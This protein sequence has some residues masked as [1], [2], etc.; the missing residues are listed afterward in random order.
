[1]QRVVVIGN[2][3]GGKSTLSRRLSARLSLPCHEI[4]ALLWQP[5]WVETPADVYGAEHARLLAGE[6]W[7]IEGLGRRDSI[8]MRLARASDIVLIDLPLWRHFQFAA[9]RQ[10]AWATGR[11]AH[12][13]GGHA[14]L[15]PIEA[16]FRTIDEVDRIWMP[17]VRDRVA[18]CESAGTRVHRLVTV[19]DLDRF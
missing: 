14:E 5:G 7:I 3:G 10:V 6:R 2:S 18:A 8:P 17:E 13:P 16:L 19:E 4:D 12:P 15:P 9:E 11:L 1:M